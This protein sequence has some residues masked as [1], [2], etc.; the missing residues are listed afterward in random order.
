MLND[1]QKYTAL[2]TKYPSLEFR[3]EADTLA[4]ATITWLNGTDITEAN[5][6]SALAAYDALEYSRNRK[7]KYDLLNQDE[8]RFDDLEN[9]TTTWQDAINAIKLE[10]PK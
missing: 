3:S 6:N 9:T 7:A 5:Y 8:L 10:Y 2:L 4:Y 1:N